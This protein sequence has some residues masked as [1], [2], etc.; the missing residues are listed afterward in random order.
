MEKLDPSQIFDPA[1]RGIP[2]T[3][4]IFKISKEPR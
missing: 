3:K 4:Q 2:K 1:Q